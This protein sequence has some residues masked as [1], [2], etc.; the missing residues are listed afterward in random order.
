MEYE[1]ELI[2]SR[3]KTIVIEIRQDCSV[4]VRAPMRAPKKEITL[5]VEEK[6]DWIEKNL[7]KMR[8]RMDMQPLQEKLTDAQIEE[9]KMRARL[10]IPGKVYEYAQ[11]MGVTYRRVSIRCQ[12][13]LWGSCTAKGN[14]SF[15]CLLMMLPEDVREYVIVHELCH[16]LELNHSKKF[17]AQVA[18]YCPDHKR[19]RK[20]LKEEGNALFLRV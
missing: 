14:L 12:K 1:I 19:L 20:Q 10:Y 16:I 9:L 5:F 18:R 13:T 4:I 8:L 2:R 7:R 17:W 15:N 6:R 3:R 11:K